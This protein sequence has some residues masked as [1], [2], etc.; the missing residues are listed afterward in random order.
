MSSLYSNVVVVPE[1]VGKTC[2]LLRD[3]LT[4]TE[5]GNCTFITARAYTPFFRNPQPG[6]VSGANIIDMAAIGISAGLLENNRTGNASRVMDAFKRVH[7]EVR[8]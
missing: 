6:Y 2:L 7:N 1:R 3:E 4:S 5:Y 8:E